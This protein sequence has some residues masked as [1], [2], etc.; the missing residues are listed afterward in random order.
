MFY[1]NLPNGSST[2]V[3][4]TSH[5]SNLKDSRPVTGDGREKKMFYFKL[6]NGSNK[7]VEHYHHHP[8]VK[9]SSL[10]AAAGDGREKKC[11]ILT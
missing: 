2:L 7:V 5:H 6:S 3:E 1:F 8:N 4:H 10:V 11:S 9:G